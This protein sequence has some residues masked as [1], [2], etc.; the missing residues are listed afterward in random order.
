[1]AGRIRQVHT[2]F[3]ARSP[4]QLLVTAAPHSSPWLP[5]GYG[6]N[7]R[8][9]ALDQQADLE[10]RL[11]NPAQVAA[12]RK[13]Q[14]NRRRKTDWLDAA[15]ICE[16]LGR[17]ERGAVHLDASPAAALR[18]LWS[19][20]KELVD[21]RSRLYQQAG[22]LVHCLWPGFSA[23]DWQAGSPRCSAIRSAPRPA[24]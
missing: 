5:D 10:V 23:K 1:M 24:G 18:P 19:G 9:A 4:A 11:V 7:I 22:A 6:Q 13:Q 2:F 15:A 16:L 14:G 17:G 21:A 8:E 20:R 12:V 3:R